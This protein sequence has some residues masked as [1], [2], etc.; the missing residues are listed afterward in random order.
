M[1]LFDI[2]LCILILPFTPFIYIYNYFYNRRLPF[3]CSSKSAFDICIG[4]LESNS[5]EYGIIA[6]PNEYTDVWTR[7][8][9]FSLMGLDHVGLGFVSKITM[10][11]LTKFQRKDGLIPLY[12][13]SGDAYTKLICRAKA[14]GKVLRVAHCASKAHAAQIQKFDE[15]KHMTEKMQLKEKFEQVM[16]KKRPRAEPVVQQ[17]VHAA[18]T[19]KQKKNTENMALNIVAH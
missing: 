12:I 3:L 19:K 6:S 2:L 18:S 8:A 7:D 16:Q 15:F 5:T 14:Q 9:F 10:T 4:I 13:G 11:T 1:I 17:Q